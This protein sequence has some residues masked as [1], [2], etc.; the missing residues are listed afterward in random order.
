MRLGVFG[1]SFDPVHYGHLLLAEC[2]LDQARLDTV[3]FVPAAQQP[4]KP[5][6]PR[7]SSVDRLAMLEIVCRE[8]EQFRASTLEIDRGGVSYTAETLESIHDL[9]P[10]AELFFLMGADSL[11]D[12]PQWHRRAEIFKLATPLVVY[13]AD[14]A[15]PNFDLLRPFLNSQRVDEI[16]RQQVE[17]P[18]TAISSSQIRAAVADRGPWE[19]LVPAQVADYIRQHRL[20]DSV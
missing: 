18:A 10:T 2:C 8:R 7:A 4:L 16:S 12:L 13:R 15:P 19:K 11:A 14:A 5:H 17:M 1:G 6:G 3:W 9:H 20:Y